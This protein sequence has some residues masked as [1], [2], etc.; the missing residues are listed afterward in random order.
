MK[1]SK[2][3]TKKKRS[4][5]AKD[6]IDEISIKQL[7]TLAKQAS[8]NAQRITRALGLPNYVIRNGE[9]IAEHP[10]GEIEFIK[11]VPKVKSKIPIKK[12]MVICLKQKD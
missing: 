12:G 8:D 10:N 6:D 7:K 11:K 2:N 4:T 9:F 3:N 5:K 1:D